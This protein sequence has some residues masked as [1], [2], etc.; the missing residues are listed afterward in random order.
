MQVALRHQ[1]ES[2]SAG[3]QLTIGHWRIDLK[4]RTAR[5]ADGGELH[6]TPIEYRL[7]EALA[8]HA[9][10]VVTHRALLRQVWGP[11]SS[12]QTQYLRV[13][14]KQLRSQARAGPGAAAVAA[15]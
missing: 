11:A 12:Q 8:Q 15:H 7:L 1:T 2:G 3:A 4:A 5:D 6:L 14:M 9:G 13:Y 10:L